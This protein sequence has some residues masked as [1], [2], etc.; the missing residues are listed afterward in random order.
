MSKWDK[1]TLDLVQ[2]T[3]KIMLISLTP[4]PTPTPRGLRP[5]E[6]H[7]KFVDFRWRNKIKLHGYWGTD[8]YLD[9]STVQRIIHRV[10]FWHCLPNIWEVHKSGRTWGGTFQKSSRFCF[11][12]FTL[13]KNHQGNQH[14]K[15]QSF[16]LESHYFVSQSATKLFSNMVWWLRWHTPVSGKTMSR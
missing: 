12:C 8:G 1:C 9:V 10:R 5:Y 11:L 7:M 14:T 15:Y 13:D 4:T 3:V 2:T 16:L 6:F